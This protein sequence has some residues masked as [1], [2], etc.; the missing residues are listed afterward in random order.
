[1]G[2]KSSV[3]QVAD[4]DEPNHVLVALGFQFGAI[5]IFVLPYFKPE[6]PHHDIELIDGNLLMHWLLLILLAI[7]LM[8]FVDDANGRYLKQI[9]KWWPWSSLHKASRWFILYRIFVGARYVA[10]AACVVL[11]L[12]AIRY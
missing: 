1:M 10:L 7:S 3:K 11:W 5:C 9:G 4:L 12:A 2:H 8:M 6:V